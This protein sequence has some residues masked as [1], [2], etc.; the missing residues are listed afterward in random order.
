MNFKKCFT[1]L[2]LLVAFF[3][4]CKKEEAIP[5]VGLQQEG[6][7][8]T[9]HLGEAITLRARV[10]N[11]NGTTFDWKIN[12]TAAGTDSILKFTASA[13]GMFRVVVTARNTVSIDSVAYN[14]KVWGKYENGFFMLQEGQYGNDNG[15]LW[16]Y[17]Y[18]SNQ[19]VK[20]VFKTENPGKSLGPNTATLQFATVYRD[21]MYMAVKVGGPLVVADA[22]T[23]KE[24]GR[25]DH[26]PQDEGYAFVGV[27]DSRGLLSAIDGVYRVNLTGPVLG[28]KVAGI[29]GPAGDMILAGDYVFVMTKDDGVVALKAADFSVAKKFGIG[30]AGFARTK[31]GSI[32]VTGKD[33]LVK[34]NPV[35]LAVDRV[36][37]PF[38][39][40]NPWAFLAWRSGSLTASASG[41]AV[42]I[43][44]REAV[45]VIGE[46][47]VGGTRLYRYQ[48]GNAASL[49]APFLTLPAGQYFY[50][51]AVRYNER[52]KELVVIALTDKFGGSNDN[53][54]LMYDA[55]TANLKETVRYTGYYFPA[56]PVFY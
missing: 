45:E 29:N 21:K 14:V 37:L 8:D 19:V 52:R 6:R 1:L 22:H 4:A 23:M 24:T 9:L 44:E 13:S 49:S 51:S 50:G 32:W 7:S 47:E 10:A 3:T 46:I 16:Y 39:T 35:S 43:A 55:V 34:I 38:K 2:S 40:T 26:L 54:W 18:D 28:A 41:D 36:K 15:D 27:D 17:S 25:I 53:R 33:S 42:Y 48:P 12:G 20:N 11:V 30:D 5:G 31:D 56:L